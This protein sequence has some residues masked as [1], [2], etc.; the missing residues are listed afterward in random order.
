M[1]QFKESLQVSTKNLCCPTTRRFK[2]L[3]N[4]SEVMQGLGWG[5]VSGFNILLTLISDLFRQF[6]NSVCQEIK[7]VKERRHAKVLEGHLNELGLV[8]GPASSTMKE[9]TQV[10]QMSLQKFFMTSLF[11]NKLELSWIKFSSNW[12]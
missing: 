2:I 3:Q 12:N 6:V 10:I 1:V 11:H 4:C 7:I 8:I 5:W 9:E